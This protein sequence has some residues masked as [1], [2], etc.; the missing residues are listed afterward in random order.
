MSTIEQRRVQNLMDRDD[1]ALIARSV[2]FY[3]RVFRGAGAYEQRDAV[4]LADARHHARQLF[5][6][7]PVAIYGVA[8]TS[9]GER[10]VF[11][12]NV[13]PRRDQPITEGDPMTIYVIAYRVPA[14]DRP[15]CYRLPAGTDKVRAA[16]FVQSLSEDVGTLIV[17]TADDVR[18]LSGPLMVK[19]YNELIRRSNE[20]NDLHGSEARTTVKKFENL[21]IGSNRLFTEITAAASLVSPEDFGVAIEAG[22][23]ASEPAFEE[24]PQRDPAPAEPPAEE[25][26][27][28]ADN[29]P[30]EETPMAKAKSKPKR[31]SKIDPDGKISIL[32]DKNP[33]R[34]GSASAKRF[35]LYKNGMKVSTFLEKGGTPADL[36]HDVKHKFIKI[37]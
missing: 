27:T 36:T 4:S 21:S 35:A 30:A 22:A 32:V 16:G 26:V 5:T 20:K 28:T 18:K 29:A 15:V 23:A 17:E 19:L 6:G 12:E 13:D 11:I 14:I 7:R 33:K 2:R 9:V 31:K 24:D 37:G 10:S 1:I 3:A 8:L 25:N 34:E